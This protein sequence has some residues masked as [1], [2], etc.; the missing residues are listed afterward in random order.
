MIK[1]KTL[2]LIDIP[3][4][5]INYSNEYIKDCF[6]ISFKILKS[7]FTDKLING[8]IDKSKFLNKKFLGITEYISQKFH[9]K[10]K[11]M[12]IYNRELSVCPITTHLPLK[13]VSKSIKKI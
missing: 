12:L 10:R 7:G 11:A 13:L 9:S 5:N 6:D 4:N 3:C 1:N 8:P 2:N